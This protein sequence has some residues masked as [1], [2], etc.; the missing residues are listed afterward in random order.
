MRDRLSARARGHIPSI[1]IF[2]P[3]IT[4]VKWRPCLWERILAMNSSRIG[5][6]LTSA[7][8]SLA[9]VLAL[10]L[11][12]LSVDFLAGPA[13]PFDIVQAGSIHWGIVAAI[14]VV[15]LGIQ[16]FWKAPTE[17]TK[18]GMVV[19]ATILWLSLAIFFNFNGQPEWGGPIAFFT[20]VG[21]LGIVL[22]WTRF[23]ADDITF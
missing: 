11:P 15:W 2:T 19:S 3:A 7:A 20:L 12:I 21:G 13:T 17:N 22:A 4:L 9:L 5:K 1:I 6:P 23:L 14:L 8:L 18:L 16:F 10:V